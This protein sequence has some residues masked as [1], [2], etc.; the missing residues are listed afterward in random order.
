MPTC[1]V[2]CLIYLVRDLVVELQS[3]LTGSYKAA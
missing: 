3:L 1:C 2:I